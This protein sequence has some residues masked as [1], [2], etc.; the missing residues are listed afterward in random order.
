MR[1]PFNR[2][3]NRGATRANAGGLHWSGRG[4]HAGFTLIEL[5]VVIAIISILAAMLLPALTRAKA[6]AQAIACLSNL[7]QLQ[8]CWLMYVDDNNGTMPPNKWQSSSDGPVSLPGSWVVGSARV[9]RNTTNIQNGVLFRYITSAAIYHCPADTSRT[10]TS[11]GSFTKLPQLRTRSYALNCWLNGKQWPG[12][13]DCPF[14]RA[15]QLLKPPPSAVFV[16]LDE[17]A[18]TIEDGHF[19]QNAYP[20]STWQDVP[21]DLHNQ[22]CNLSYADGRAERK[23]WR[24][25]KAGPDL[26]WNRS[27]ANAKDLL[28]LRDLQA[29]IPQ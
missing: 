11:F 16:F 27:A 28:D 18:C 3:R 1:A 26:V 22:L 5:L 13:T 21:G 14:I 23:K 12:D 8:S 15:S 10:E 24:W 29:T 25:T 20:S 19:A 4:P 2:L 9:D 17:Q 6:K 7:R